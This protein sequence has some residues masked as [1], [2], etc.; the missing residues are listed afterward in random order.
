MVPEELWTE[1]VKTAV[2]TLNRTPTKQ[3]PNSTPYELWTGSKAKL[4][5]VK[6]FGCVA[7]EFIPEQHRTKWNAKS[8]K[9]MFVGYD[10]D[11]PNYKLFDPQTRKFS[12]SRNVTF[13]EKECWKNDEGI[14]PLE[15]HLT[16][17]PD[18]P[19]SQ[20]PMGDE[21]PNAPLSSDDVGTRR[22]RDRAMLPAIDRY[23]ANMVEFEEPTSYKE[24]LASSDAS[25][26]RVAINDELSALAKNNTWTLTT[27]PPH[28]RTISA[29][30]VFKIKCDAKGGI[31]RCKARLVA[32][33][34]LQRPGIDFNET[35][36]PVVRYE[37]VR[38]LL[39]VAS[40]RDFE[41]GQFDIKTAFLNGELE[42]DI[43][44][45]I[46]EGVN[47][48]NKNLVCK[49]NKSLYGLKQSPRQWNKRFNEFL[50]LHDFKSNEA[51]HCVYH[52]SYGT[53]ELILALYVDDGL[54]ISSSKE[55]IQL[56]L[57][58]L[59][60]Q[61]EITIGD[62]TYFVG[63]EIK[64]DRDKRE[65]FISQENYLCRVLN[66]FNMT[67]AKAVAIPFEAGAHLDAGEPL[68]VD[69][70]LK[71]DNVP[72]RQAV[73]SLMFAATVSRP[74]IM[75]AVSVV[76]RY[77]SNP[78]PVHWSAVKRIFR[79]LRGTTSLGIT[80]GRSNTELVGYTDS[81][82][83]GDSDTRRST[84]GYVFKIGGGAVT[85][86]SQ[87]QKVVA[88]STTEAEYI[89]ASEA[90][91]EAIWLRLLLS[92]IGVNMDNPIEMRLDNQGSIKLIGNPQF[93]KRTKHID[94][95]YHFIREKF[96][97][98]DI[99]VSYVPSED[100]LADILT[101]GLAKNVFQRLR[102]EI[103]VDKFSPV[104]DAKLTTDGS[105]VNN[106]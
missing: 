48:D 84:S 66:K 57:S 101:K 11:A 70:Q 62:G 95:R 99:D 90:T 98:G 35:F 72:Y 52:G 94:V 7:Y 4:D 103:G 75:Y 34:Y 32:K 2:Y 51:D 30:W 83:A 45:D 63:L 19:I 25:K 41:I 6:T 54:I 61:F 71:M 27:L 88:L 87:R 82:Y 105:V 67:T 43:F 104:F 44:M 21:E 46:P 13:N 33:G 85:W 31:D 9:K 16:D 64:R 77:L 96:E 37:S 100:E 56:V 8:K 29:K 40:Y 14:K 39:S 28:K 93:H 106:K 73:G 42:E 65:L 3:A 76:S 74:D 80:Y 58:E 50:K 38:V 24:A 5:H 26:W 49:L 102:G 89:A 78:K 1:A 91:K 86:M 81:D 53:D 97:N 92:G 12:V 69:E 18:V 36:A 59:K 20:E 15:L 79:Y 23:Q 60:K 17:E 10:K 55:A 47:V 22:L 68:N